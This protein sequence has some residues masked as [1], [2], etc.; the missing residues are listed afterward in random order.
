MERYSILEAVAVPSS[1]PLQASIPSKPE[2]W[3]PPRHELRF[4][5]EDGGQSLAAWARRDLEATLQLLADR[6]QYITGATGAAIALRDGEHIICRAS[7]GPAAPEV[8]SFLEVSSGLSG[9]SVRTRMLMRCDDAA[10]DPRVNRE[11]CRQLGIASF[12]V[13]PLLREDE[14]V[15]IFEIFGG[16]P[17]AFQDR[18]IHAL[19]RMGEMVNTALDQVSRPRAKKAAAGASQTDIPSEPKPAAA[20]QPATQVQSTSSLTP[21]AEEEDE[22]V[23]SVEDD[24]AP[25]KAP[26]PAVVAPQPDFAHRP[27]SVQ[28]PL[29]K[30]HAIHTCVACGFPVSE[31]RTLCLDCEASPDRGFTSD[32]AG[33]YS[34]AP[35]F[36]AGLEGDGPQPSGIRGWIA[37]HKYLLGTIAVIGSTLAI[38]IFR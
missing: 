33:T 10:N 17:H 3:Q 11:G 15:G 32:P 30:T 7:S 31:G 6:A 34:D 19:E 25:A 35:S 4:P 27:G 9:E 12:L 38:L 26:T 14:V 37:G 22:V 2:N 36:L 18:D 8:G 23:L 1:H 28:K 20:K 21:H 13:L 5:G 16:M 24:P 29:Q